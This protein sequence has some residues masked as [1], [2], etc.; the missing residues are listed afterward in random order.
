MKI[1]K[2]QALGG[3]VKVPADKSITHRAIM[4]ASVAEG[5]SVINNYL[6]SA[7]C[8]STIHCFKLLG[9]DVIVKGQSLTVSG[10]GLKLSAPDKNLDA[11]NSGTT[12]RLMSGI[13]AGQNFSATITG[14][15]S[16]SKRP[17][18]RIIEPLSLM[19]AKIEHNGFCLPITI[20]GKNP[21]KAIEYKGEK[22]SAQVKSAVL[23]AALFSDG[24]TV[25]TEPVKSRD[26]TEKML[27][28][29]GAK[30]EI[31]G[32]TV[33]VYPCERLNPLN[34]TV[35]ADISSAAFFI[36]AALIC[37][38]S[39]IRMNAVGVNPTRDG[40][41]EV[42]K[43]MGANIKLEHF[44]EVSGELT[45]DIIA[46]TSQL[47]AVNIGAE[48][49]PRLIDELPIIALAATQAQGTTVITGAAELRVKE[50]DRIHATCDV[51]S[52][53]GA[54]IKKTEDGFIITGPAKLKGAKVSSFGDHRIAMMAA[55]A[56]LIADGETEIDDADCVKISFPEFFDSLKGLCR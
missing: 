35:P 15:E 56:G 42:Y 24:K 9:A 37:P 23:F 34:I 44:N 11:G 19:G 38:N 26:Y 1:N 12:A 2:V 8:L 33:S 32:N 40:I 20:N 14:D 27:I 7:D 5:K 18:K 10:A 4:I 16:L 3:E 17:M 55:V 30:I 54:D 28:A 39:Q 49:I 25:Y 46:Q 21:L 50:T 29:S 36:T 41:L 13:L 47:T 48:I 6:P 22:P 31:A 53:L 43:D 51:L 52:A 45:A